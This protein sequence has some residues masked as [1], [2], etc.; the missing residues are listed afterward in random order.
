MTWG[1]TGASSTSTPATTPANWPATASRPGGRATGGGPTLGRRSCWCCATAGGATA[2]H[3]TSSRSSCRGWGVGW[4]ME[5][6]G[7]QA[8]PYCSKYNPIEHRLSPPLARACRGVTFRTLETVR[9]YM[10]KA[11]TTTGLEVEVGILE[12]VYETGRKCAAG[13]KETVRIVFDELLPR[14][15]YRAVPE[16]V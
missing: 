1:S 10:S 15:N 5:I 13:F 9:H 8:P 14:W 12:K 11:G 7:A 6:G 16:P 4:G 3:G 2:R